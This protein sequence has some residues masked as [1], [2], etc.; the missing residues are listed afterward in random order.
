MHSIEQPSCFSHTVSFTFQHQVL[1]TRD[2]F[3]LQNKTL[4]KMIQEN[5]RAKAISFID[6]GLIQENPQIIEKINRYF[7]HSH[8]QAPQLVT[9]PIVVQGGES[10]KQDPHLIQRLVE[11]LQEKKLCRHSWVIVIGGGAVLDAVCFAAS[12]V[13][14]GIRQIRIPST[15]LAQADAGVG[16]KNGVD[17]RG[18]KN[19]LGTFCPPH[20][21]INDATLLTT[22]NLKEWTSGMAEA[23]KVALIK[24]SHFFD[25]IEEHASKLYRR[26]LNLMEQ[27]VHRSAELHLHHIATSGDPFERGSARPLDFGHWSA[28]KLEQLTDFRIRHG[29]AVAIGM[30]LDCVYANEI[31]VLSLDHLNRI[32]DCLKTLG[33]PIW[34]EAL[35]ET[36]ESTHTLSILAG[37]EEFREHLGGDLSI[38]VLM[39]PGSAIN[40]NQ[41]RIELM[42]RS[43]YKLNNYYEVNDAL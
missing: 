42:K 6:E 8:A 11:I 12:L 36:E 22:L 34:D 15:V 1:F 9:A 31:G 26:D 20:A 25:W 21:V 37:L 2:V 29:Y 4:V 13:H 14:R 27:L 30:A 43:I 35:L 3:E 17:Y 28:H 19:F 18:S 5:S 7:L 38:P 33:L 39:T 23:V 10:A 24:D 16:I 41:I 32:L 40:L